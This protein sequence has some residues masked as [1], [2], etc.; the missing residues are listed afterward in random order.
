MILPNQYLKMIYYFSISP[1]GIIEMLSKQRRQDLSFTII[2]V[3]LNIF[4]IFWKNWSPLRS[5]SFYLKLE[6]PLQSSTDNRK[7]SIFSYF[8]YQKCSG[9]YRNI[10]LH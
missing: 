2:N 4:I 6:I 3:K 1:N 9:F 10:H 8:K 5:C 7:S